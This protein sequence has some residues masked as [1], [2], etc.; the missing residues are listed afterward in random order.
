MARREPFV[1]VLHR[2]DGSLTDLLKATSC[3]SL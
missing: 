2:L 3:Y 1:A